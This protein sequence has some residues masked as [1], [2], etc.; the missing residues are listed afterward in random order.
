MPTINLPALDSLPALPQVEGLR[1]V[2][3][4]LWEQDDVVA[5]WLGGSFARGE[6][7]AYSDMDLRV[8]VRPEALDQWRGSDLRLIFGE[9]LVGDTSFRLGK[10]ILH[11]AALSNG[12][13]YH[14]PIQSL[15]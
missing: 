2:A 12:D 5:L 9:S 11:Q 13:I 14:L 3:S 8:A 10:D 4:T 15:E 1:R 7:D 6:A